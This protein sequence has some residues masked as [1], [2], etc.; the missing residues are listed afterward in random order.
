[1]GYPMLILMFA[2]LRE[3]GFGGKPKLIRSY[4]EFFESKVK[5]FG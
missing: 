5:L 2:S 4:S 3:M 1:M